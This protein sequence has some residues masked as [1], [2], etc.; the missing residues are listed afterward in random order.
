MNHDNDNLMTDEEAS[1][2][3]S[4]CG[5]RGRNALPMIRLHDLMPAHQRQADA[6][7]EALRH[8]NLLDES[9]RVKMHRSTSLIDLLDPT[10]DQ[11]QPNESTINNALNTDRSPPGPQ[12]P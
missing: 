7:I 8:L 4:R 1:A 3:R 5:M 9:G 2:H 12:P 10:K 6:Q 11:D